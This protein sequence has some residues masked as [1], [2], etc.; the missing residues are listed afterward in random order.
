MD[1]FLYFF[2]RILA[3]PMQPVGMTTVTFALGIFLL[4]RGKR[5]ASKLF[6]IGSFSI[7]FF[8]S[9]GWTGLSLLK[10]LEDKAG[11][12]ADPEKLMRAGI[13]NIVVL[14]KS[15]IVDAN[16]PADRWF[17]TLPRVMEGVRLLDKIP[18]AKLI[19]SGSAYSSAVAMEELPLRLGVPKESLILET[20]AFNTADEARLIRPLLGK[21]PFALVTSAVHMPRAMYLFRSEGTNPIPCPC[22]YLTHG[23][24]PIYLLLVPCVGG[25][26]NSE[27]ALHEYYSLLFYWAKDLNRKFPTF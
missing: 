11:P 12:Y 24:P 8:F 7:F 9:L 5:L 18:Q 26:R 15:R 2:K 20:R 13:R 25:F 10:P 14:S 22:D 16:T 27:T 1:T 17:G 4:F 23:W 21:E 6:L 3:W 19:L